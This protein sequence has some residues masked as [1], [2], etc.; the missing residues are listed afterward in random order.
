MWGLGSTGARQYGC[1]EDIYLGE[2][3]RR[4]PRVGRHQ[5]QELGALLVVHAALRRRK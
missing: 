4:Q 2:A 5:L 3:A 1:T